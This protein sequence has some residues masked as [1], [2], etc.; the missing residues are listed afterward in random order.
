MHLNLCSLQCLPHIHCLELD[1]HVMSVYT[2][3]IVSVSCGCNLQ[4]R[5]QVW[6]GL[7]CHVSDVCI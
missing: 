7:S 4:C 3:A 6:H 5:F 2:E 1:C